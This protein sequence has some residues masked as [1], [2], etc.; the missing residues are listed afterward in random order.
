MLFNNKLKVNIK[1]Y[2]T[3]HWGRGVS[4][5]SVDASRDNVPSKNFAGDLASAVGHKRSLQSHP[6]I[7]R[8]L[9]RTP[10]GKEQLLL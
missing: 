1:C 9:N 4:Q 8:I 7:V 10:F 3:V 5:L 2:K 6:F